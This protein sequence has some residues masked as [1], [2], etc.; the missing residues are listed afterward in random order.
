MEKNAIKNAHCLCESVR[1]LNGMFGVLK[2]AT[3]FRW[4]NR[5]LLC[6]PVWIFMHFEK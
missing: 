2:C 4:L 1:L 3:E 5:L 6:T